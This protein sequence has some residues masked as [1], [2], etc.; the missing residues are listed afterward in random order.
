MTVFE[1]IGFFWTVFATGIFTACFLIAA[2]LSIHAG[3][4]VLVR[5]YRRGDIEEARDVLEQTELRRMTRTG[6]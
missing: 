2:A 3:I 1:T 5:R 6:Q 4:A